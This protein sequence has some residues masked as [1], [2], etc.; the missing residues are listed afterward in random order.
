MSYSTHPGGM[1]QILLPSP[2]RNEET[3][4]QWVTAAGGWASK[5]QSRPWALSLYSTWP[6][7]DSGLGDLWSP[8]LLLPFSS[9]RISHCGQGLWFLT[10]HHPQTVSG[11]GKMLLGTLEINMSQDPPKHLTRTHWFRAMKHLGDL[12]YCQTK[13]ENGIHLVGPQERDKQVMRQGK[14]RIWKVLPMKSW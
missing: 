6:S 8:T 3:K 12:C 14:R 13:D 2:G 10:P 7:W 5:W 1:R 11:T 4:E 9:N